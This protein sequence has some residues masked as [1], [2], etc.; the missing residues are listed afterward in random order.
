MSFPS[1][2]LYNVSA[3]DGTVESDYLRYAAIPEQDKPKYIDYSLTDFASYK[4][5]L[6]DYIRAVYP[7]EFT[8]FV[9]SDMGVMFV[10][11]FAYLASVISLKAD[12]V[13]NE[14][15]ITTVKNDANLEKLLNLIGVKTKGPSAAKAECT[16]TLSSDF[17]DGDPTHTVISKA[18]RTLR[19]GSDKDGQPVTFT[20]YRGN[21]DG[22]IVFDSSGIEDLEFNVNSGERVMGNFY[23][24]EGTL[25]EEDHTFSLVDENFEIKLAEAPVVEGSIAVS[26]SDGTLW[27]EIDSLFLASGN[28]AVFEK[29]YDENYG[30]A[31]TFGNGTKGMKPTPGLA[32]KVF[33]RSGGGER[34]NVGRNAVNVSVPSTKNTGSTMNVSVRN[35]TKATGGRD[36]ES[37]AHAKKY[38]PHVFKS[39]HRCVTGEDYTAA[40]NNFSSA[41]GTVGKA[42]A[43]LRN[44]GAGANNIDIYCLAKASQLQLERCSLL[45]KGELLDHL[46]NLKMMTDEITL[47]DGVIRTLDL[48][49][50]VL[51]DEA[52]VHRRN[53]I[54]QVAV[55]GLLA[56]FDVDRREFGEAL[57][58]SKLQNY[59]NELPGVRYFTVDNFPGDIHVNVN[60][61][62]QLNNFELTVDIV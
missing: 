3:F 4:D 30:A 23:M 15:Y 41:N 19:A 32:V 12:F 26:S 24:L 51:I 1:N 35:I 62:I 46:N 57:S 2:P 7:D 20:L 21:A 8:N 5:A 50:T 61:I 29:K 14:G 60:E 37:A 9:E 54:K 39:Q 38:Y 36:K 45:L 6:L 27:Q 48:N 44:N 33:Y 10:E 59:M 17:F 52:D 31:L 40:A 49:C 18:N 34:G 25:Q 28:Q 13:A 53:A 42:M 58:L 55:D 43:V 56:Y 22:T 16:V 11:L 47:V